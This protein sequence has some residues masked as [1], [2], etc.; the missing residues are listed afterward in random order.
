MFAASAVFMIYHAYY[1]ATPFGGLIDW[2]TYY[3]SMRSIMHGDVLGMNY[4]PHLPY[5]AEHFSPILILQ[6][7]LGL[8]PSWLSYLLAFSMQLFALSY[9]AMRLG[10]RLGLGVIVP[11]LTIIVPAWFLNPVPET[12]DWAALAPVAAGLLAVNDEAAAWLAYALSAA[13]IELIPPYLLAATYTIIYIY[14]RLTGSALADNRRLAKAYAVAF[15]TLAIQYFVLTYLRIIT[16]YPIPEV[17]KNIVGLG[18][19]NVSN[20][21]FFALSMFINNAPAFLTTPGLA[22]I[23]IALPLLFTSPI[24]YAFLVYY[25]APFVVA[26]IVVVLL[27]RSRPNTVVLLIAGYGASIMLAIVVSM[28]PGPGLHF[29]PAPTPLLAAEY[30]VSKYVH[31]NETGLI[32]VNGQLC[33]YGP[34]VIVAHCAPPAPPIVYGF[35]GSKLTIWLEKFITPS[36]LWFVVNPKSYPAGCGNATLIMLG[37]STLVGGIVEC[38][39][40]GPVAV[41]HVNPVEVA[42]WW[43]GEVLQYSAVGVGLALLASL[44]VGLISRIEGGYR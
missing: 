18:Q 1:Y 42:E 28:L 44:C 27:T 2:A 43:I 9:F 36:N 11:V 7:P 39:S 21:V 40:P 25:M 33:G 17:Y 20:A 41:V 4:V 29:T 15:A 6:A 37:N 16:H 19:F 31:L 38:P 24:Y 22:T 3:Q 30:Y 10:R 14:S 8:L 5:L 12:Y 26:T 13:G 23:A 32:A 35:N 34:S